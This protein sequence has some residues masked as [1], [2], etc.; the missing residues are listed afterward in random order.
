M[1]A[2]RFERVVALPSEATAN[3][4]YFVRGAGTDRVDL[5]VTGNDGTPVLVNTAKTTFNMLNT[6]GDSQ[7]PGYLV[8]DFISAVDNIDRRLAALGQ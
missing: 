4:L 2:V 6:V 7:I 1:V 8:T 3:T 5:F